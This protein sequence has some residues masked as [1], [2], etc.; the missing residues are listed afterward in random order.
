MRVALGAVRETMIGTVLMVTGL[1]FFIACIYVGSFA[2]VA[3][4]QWLASL[5]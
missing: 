3:L 5:I 4:W 2:T 1:M